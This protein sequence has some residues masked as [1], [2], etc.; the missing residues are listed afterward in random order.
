MSEGLSTHPLFAIFASSF[1]F[2]LISEA[3]VK[4]EGSILFFN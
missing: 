2:L 4:L 3:L 1:F